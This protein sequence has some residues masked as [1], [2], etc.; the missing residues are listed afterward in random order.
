[1]RFESGYI[2]PLWIWSCLI[3]VVIWV[4]YTYK[5]Y[6]V[7]G[8][9][10]IEFS[11]S[12]LRFFVALLGLGL[13][14]V[15]N[16]FVTCI[17][18]RY[19]IL[20]LHIFLVIPTFVYWAIASESTI[21]LINFIFSFLLMIWISGFNV[22]R[23]RSVKNGQYLSIF[24]IAIVVTIYLVGFQTRDYLK[25]L[26]F[27]FA[28]VYSFRSDIL[29]Y[30]FGGFYGY[31]KEWMTVIYMVAITFAFKH[32]RYFLLALVC[33]LM[34]MHFAITSAKMY[35]FFA[36][37][38]IFCLVTFELG[39]NRIFYK[40]LMLFFSALVC[41]SAF[42]F[43]SETALLSGLVTYRTFLAPAVLNFQYFEFFQSNPHTYFAG[44]KL[45]LFVDNPYSAPIP[46]VIGLGFWGDGKENFS[47]TGIWGTGYQHIG[48]LGLYLYSAILGVILSIFS[49]LVYTDFQSR[50]W[51]LP[52]FSIMFLQFRQGDLP[53][54][55]VT[56][57]VLLFLAV[58]FFLPKPSPLR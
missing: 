15:C 41:I 13:V 2:L 48:Y 50:V 20:L 34:I 3:F 39:S 27:N 46:E 53:S 17:T 22:G 11:P 8:Y 38:L 18:R 7:F 52:A 58:I 10:K 24:L 49:S 35:L 26:N 56:N 21:F 1:M 6:P 57:G 30:S 5:V 16:G 23:L 36:M 31:I 33:G 40:L 28:E 42:E 12:N 51:Y 9:A 55:L 19:P 54:I 45:G 47:N 43:M 32:G 25:Y 37:L 4:S 14:S 44:T 29:E